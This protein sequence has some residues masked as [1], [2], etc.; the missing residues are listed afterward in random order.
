M[1]RSIKHNIAG[2]TLIELLVV[3][4]IIAIL[5]AILFPVFAQAREKGRQASCM[6]NEKQLT[7]AIIQYQQDYDE[8]YPVQAIPAAA[9]AYEWQQ[10]WIN[11]VQPY[12]KSLDVFVCPS[13]PHTV[14]PVGDPNYTGPLFSYV[15]N[16]ALGYDWKFKNGWVTDG[17]INAGFSWASD[18]GNGVNDFHVSP[19]INAEV[20][21]PSST[22]LLTE[23]HKLVG[24][25][26]PATYQGAFTPWD[27]I[28]TG[29]GGQDGNI[30]VPG[31]TASGCGAPDPTSNGQVTPAHTGRANFAFSDGHVKSLDPKSTVQMHSNQNSNCNSGIT[32]NN[33]FFM[34]SAVRTTDN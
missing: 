25:T 8:A 27:T 9:N 31:Q 21:F 33:Y 34:W 5:A 24:V 23:K 17:L 28:L 30:G 3:I 15:A 7:L 1:Q 14:P 4:A 29:A 6:S 20:N 12:I 32:G 22:I 16:G 10:S 19:R 13:D 18:N 2:F 26:N 11:A